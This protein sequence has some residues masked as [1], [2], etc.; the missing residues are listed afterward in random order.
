MHDIEPY[1]KWRDYYVSAEDEHSPFYGCIY[2]EFAFTNRIYNYYI[3]PQ[4]DEFGSATLY[5]KILYTD[6]EKGFVV[7]ELIGEWN[8]CITN[9]I[10]LL[11]RNIADPLIA[12]GISKF[13]L[14]GENVLNYHSSDDCYYEEWYEDIS[15]RDGWIALLNIRDHIADEMRSVLLHHF[16]RFGDQYNQFNWRKHNPQNLYKAVSQLVEMDSNKLA[17]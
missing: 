12:S 7:F 6:Y 16:V 13:I 3:H 10:M 17:G 8:D 14:I 11:K 5:M 15:E 4:W 1:Y 2:S 9:D